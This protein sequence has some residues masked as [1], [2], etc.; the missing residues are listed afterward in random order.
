MQVFLLRF[1][2]TN[3]LRGRVV[4]PGGIKKKKLE[5]REAPWEARGL[6]EQA[7]AWRQPAMAEYSLPGVEL[8]GFAWL[9]RS[10]EVLLQ[11]G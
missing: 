4:L 3:S 7:G 6:P 10:K 1:R 5:Q 8:M 2:G 11:K 9:A